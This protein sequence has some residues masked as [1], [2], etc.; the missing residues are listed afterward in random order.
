MAFQIANKVMSDSP[1]LVDFPIR[2]CE[3][4]FSFNQWA[5]ELFFP[6]E[7]GSGGW[8]GGGG[9]GAEFNITKVL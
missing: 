3:I 4:W 9:R 6:L 7:V 5:S 1:G 8:G 2:L